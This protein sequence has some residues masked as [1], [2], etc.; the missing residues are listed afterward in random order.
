[1]KNTIEN[2]TIPSAFTFHNGSEITD[3]TKYYFVSSRNN[4]RYGPFF[5]DEQN[6]EFLRL[7]AEQKESTKKINNGLGVEL[8]ERSLPLI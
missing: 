5:F 7:L 8:Q 2:I 4:E 1:M 6:E 3:A